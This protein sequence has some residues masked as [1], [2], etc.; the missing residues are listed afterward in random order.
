MEAHGDFTYLGKGMT[1]MMIMLYSGDWDSNNYFIEVL[2]L[3]GLYIELATILIFY[4]GS[5]LIREVS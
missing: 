3:L 5:V 1:G 2:F 4:S